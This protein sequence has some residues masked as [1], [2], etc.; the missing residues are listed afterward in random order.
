MRAERGP[1]ELT[2]RETILALETDELFEERFRA[3]FANRRVHMGTYEQLASDLH[4]TAAQVLG[5]LGVD[6]RPLQAQSV[7]T[8][9]RDPR[10]AVRNWRELAAA[11]R[12]TRWEDAVVPE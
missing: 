3:T 1:V 6:A 11:L 7:K 8:G 2:P 9:E 4:G 12:D 5:F 10:V